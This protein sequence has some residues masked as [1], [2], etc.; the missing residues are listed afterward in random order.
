MY[1]YLSSTYV[2]TTT[3]RIEVRLT[4]NLHR[5]CHAFNTPFLFCPPQQR[6]QGYGFRVVLCQHHLA[7]VLN[8]HLYSHCVLRRQYIS[9]TFNSKGV[10]CTNQGLS[11][12]LI[13]PTSGRR[14]SAQPPKLALS[15]PVRPRQHADPWLR[16]SL[17]FQI[18]HFA[19]FLGCPRGRTQPRTKHSRL[20]QVYDRRAIQR[21]KH[22]P[23]GAISELNDQ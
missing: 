18:A 20:G 1:P 3:P 19:K 12:P 8:V 16:V 9:R 5:R 6:R 15:Q 7:K 11:Q 14:T 17:S 22:A 10:A 23:I 4:I 21:P 13:C 2:G